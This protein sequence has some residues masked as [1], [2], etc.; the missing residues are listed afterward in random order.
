MGA[1]SVGGIGLR[2]VSVAW[3]GAGRGLHDEFDGCKVAKQFRLGFSVGIYWRSF[4]RV[5]R[6]RILEIVWVRMCKWRINQL[7]IMQAHYMELADDPWYDT[8]GHRGFA[9][10]SSRLAQVLREEIL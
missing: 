1:L 3:Q 4:V 9:N 5:F 7:E 2:R 10:E 8:G 6:D